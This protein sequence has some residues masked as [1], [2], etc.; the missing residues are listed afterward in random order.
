AL[1]AYLESVREEERTR[2]ARE[3]HDELGQ[4]LT[5]LKMDLTW[6]RDRLGLNGPTVPAA[7]LREKVTDMAQLAD[8]TIA[9]GRRIATEL[10]PGILDDLGLVAAL[11]W[12]A[13]DFQ[14]RTGI[15]CDFTADRD[16]LALGRKQ[17]TALFR[18]A[19]ES[20][21]NVARHAQATAVQV[22]LRT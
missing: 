6:V 15:P 11:E 9:T 17:T 18:I 14:R 2:I 4:A 16:D 7:V 5:G 19:Q 10:R 21:T 3:L 20:L 8:A 13:Q 22:R 1:T 12:L